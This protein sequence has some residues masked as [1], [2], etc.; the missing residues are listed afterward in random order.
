[1]SV[2][3]NMIPRAGEWK[4]QRLAQAS[5]HIFTSDRRP[6]PESV[7]TSNVPFSRDMSC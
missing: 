2:G 5:L 7:R 6:V 3:S 1:V 4:D